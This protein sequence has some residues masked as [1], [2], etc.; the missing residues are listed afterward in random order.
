MSNLSRPTFLIGLINLR[1][2]L[3]TNQMQVAINVM[4]MLFLSCV[5]QSWSWYVHSGW[6][7][8]FCVG[9]KRVVIIVTWCWFRRDTQTSVCSSFDIWPSANQCGFWDELKDVGTQYIWSYTHCL[10]FSSIINVCRRILSSDLVTSDAR[11]IRRQN[12]WRNSEFS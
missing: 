11:F 12:Q 9:L 2:M 6:W 5:K 3:D 4:W 1:R 8:S 7:G 10:R